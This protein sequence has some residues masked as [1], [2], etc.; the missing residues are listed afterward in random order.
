MQLINCCH[1]VSETTMLV[2]SNGT[3]GSV[4]MLFAFTLL[5]VEGH[6]EKVILILVWKLIFKQASYF[7]SVFKESYIESVYSRNSSMKHFYKISQVGTKSTFDF[8]KIMSNEPYVVCRFSSTSIF[9]VQ[10]SYSKS[11]WFKALEVLGLQSIEHN[12]IGKTKKIIYYS[13]CLINTVG[14]V[15]RRANFWCKCK[16]S[17]NP[18]YGVSW[19]IRAIFVG[20]SLSWLLRICVD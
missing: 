5:H 13:I 2:L 18:K 6:L 19:L 17:T 15:P 14:I 11:F 12:I 9:G 8:L 20:C 7:G 4:G 16:I 1:W 10:V 3:K